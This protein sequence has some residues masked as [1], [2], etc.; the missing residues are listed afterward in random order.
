M[1]NQVDLKVVEE[2]YYSTHF[3]KN[4]DLWGL[5][6]NLVKVFMRTTVCTTLHNTP[7]KVIITHSIPQ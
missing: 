3:V 2:Y 4:E 5:W 1:V 7:L 6:F